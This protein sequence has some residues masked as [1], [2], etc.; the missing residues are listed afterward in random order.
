MNYSVIRKLP[1]Y[2]R[3]LLFLNLDIVDQTLV[4]A[5]YFVPALIVGGM[6]QYFLYPDNQDV[7]IVSTLISAFFILVFLLSLPEDKIEVSPPQKQYVRPFVMAINFVIGMVYATVAIFVSVKLWELIEKYNNMDKDEFFLFSCIW[8]LAWAVSFVW[9][10]IFKYNKKLF[11]KLKYGEIKGVHIL[12]VGKED[13]LSI[14]LNKKTFEFRLYDFKRRRM[15]TGDILIFNNIDNIQEYVYTEIKNLY[16]ASNFNELQSKMPPDDKQL[17]DGLAMLNKQYPP[18]VQK[19]RNV[20]AVEF[21]TVAH[22]KWDKY[23]YP[24]QH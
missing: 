6:A 20:I 14:N 15:E 1:T 11:F 3:I 5:K 4:L 23:V 13:F 8:G 9:I 7:D 21:E 18:Q 12:N 19:R 2:K 17:K 16:F 10:V 24:Q 22:D